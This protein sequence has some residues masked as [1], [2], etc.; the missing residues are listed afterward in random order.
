MNG[1]IRII[2]IAWCKQFH[3][4]QSDDRFRRVSPLAVRPDELIVEIATGQVEDQIEDDR[5]SHAAALGKKRRQG[6]GSRVNSRKTGRNR[7]KSPYPPPV[8]TN[9][10]SGT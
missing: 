5:D 3:D 7:E 10:R 9:D 1:C 8:P 2:A 6:S 4:G